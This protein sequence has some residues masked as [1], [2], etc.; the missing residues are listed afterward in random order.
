M[1][2]EILFTC[3]HGKNSMLE[4]KNRISLAQA[5][6]YNVPV[7]RARVK[8]MRGPGARDTPLEARLYTEKCRARL[9]VRPIFPPRTQSRSVVLIAQSKSDPKV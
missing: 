5:V 4:M 6:I 1:D 9:F 3:S 2:A 8:K 7:T